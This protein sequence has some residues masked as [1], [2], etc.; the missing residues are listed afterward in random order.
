MNITNTLRSGQAN[1]SRGRIKITIY[2][3]LIIPV[4]LYGAEA[5]P[6]TNRS[7]KAL[8]TFERTVLRKVFSAVRKS[9]EEDGT[10]NCMSTKYNECAAEA[11]S[12]SWKTM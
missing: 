5:W 10:T 9:T 3:F 11:I 2:K 1:P 6:V 12:D 7:G 4:C 8:R